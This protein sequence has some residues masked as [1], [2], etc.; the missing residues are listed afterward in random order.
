MC[1]CVPSFGQRQSHK[2]RSSSALF[3]HGYTIE[4]L[5]LGIIVFC[6][7][8]ISCYVMDCHKAITYSMGVSHDQAINFKSMY[9]MYVCQEVGCLCFQRVHKSGEAYGVC[10]TLDQVFSK[11]PCVPKSG[12]DFQVRGIHKD[13]DRY[14]YW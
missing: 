8:T 14:M 6:C 9:V 1:V 5:I 3:R 10:N 13:K 11:E 4:W 7:K 12:Y 2:S